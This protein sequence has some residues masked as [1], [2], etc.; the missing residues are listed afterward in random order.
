MHIKGVFGRKGFRNA[1]L[2]VLL[3]FICFSLSA[4]MPQAVYGTEISAKAYAVMEASCGQ[5]TAQRNAY[6]RLPMASTTKIMTA[7]LTLK[8]SDLYEIFT[9]D[10][11]AIQVEGTSM[12][13]QAEDTVSLYDLACGM[14]LASGNDAANAAAMRIGGSVDGFVELMNE[15]AARIGMTN[16]HFS[17][18]SGLPDEEHYSCAYDM[19][20]L[21]AA[22]LEEPLFLEICSS[23]L[24][25]A[26]VSGE[27]RTYRNHNRLLTE[28]EGCI[29]VKTGYTKAAGRCLVSAARRDN[30]TLICVTLSAPDDWNDHKKLLD[31]GFSE[32]L[33]TFLE[34]E[35]D[36]FSLNVVGGEQD[37][38][39]AYVLGQIK[40]C[41]TKEESKKVVQEWR[42]RSLYFAPVYAGQVMGQVR[43]YYKE[44]LLGTQLVLAGNSCEYK[45]IT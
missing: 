9:V 34:P 45:M 42:L 7:Y 16:T 19:A 22:A 23:V 30:I 12:G 27:V 29:G 5:I 10:G 24:K 18:P 8:Q 28:Y 40:V 36:S 26:T 2:V 21:A 3:P 14:L 11:N 33:Q 13:L 35:K 31:S 15:E 25:K 32:I 43:Y 6:D 38:V 41:L 37:T 20:L 17:N 39:N 44:K 1:V 4:A